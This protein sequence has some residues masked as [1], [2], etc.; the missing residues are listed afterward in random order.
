[1]RS[2]YRK[3]SLNKPDEHVSFNHAASSSSS[4]ANTSTSQIQNNDIINHV[5]GLNHNLSTSS[6]SRKSLISNP[7]N[8]QHLQHMG[9]NDGKIFMH[10]TNTISSAQRLTNQ[11]YNNLN[12][13][14]SATLQNTSTITNHNTLQSDRKY[15]SLSILK[16]HS[17]MFYF[18]TFS[19]KECED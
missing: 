8:F 16:M 17:K 3:G 11:N 1:M 12:T 18:K 14:S 15:C 2:K 4:S 9:P 6:S 5:I 10:D 7:T 13:N 19:S